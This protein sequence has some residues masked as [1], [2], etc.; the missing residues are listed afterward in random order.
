MTDSGCP[1]A[2]IVRPGCRGWE[3]R[4]GGRRIGG[5][6]LLYTWRHMMEKRGGGWR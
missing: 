6:L 1:A 5:E 4:E 2:V 3:G